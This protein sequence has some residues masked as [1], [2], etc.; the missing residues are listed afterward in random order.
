M[1]E[2]I[3]DTAYEAGKA[4]FSNG[5]SLRTVVD[6]LLERIAVGQ[7]GVTEGDDVKAASFALGFADAFID[8]LRKL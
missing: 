3:D 4:A 8:R 6:R 7:L 1:P 5:A 2:K